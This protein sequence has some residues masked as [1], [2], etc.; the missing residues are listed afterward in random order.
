MGGPSAAIVCEELIALGARRLVRI[1][2]CGALRDGPRAR[3][4]AGGA[5]R[6]CRP[7][8]RAPRSAPTGRVAADP[9]L[10]ERL[11]DGRRRAR[12]GGHHRPLL[13]RPRRERR[14]TGCAGAPPPWRW[15]RPRCCRLAE[16]R[17][18]EAAAVLGVTR[19]AGAG[20]VAAGGAG[21]ARGDRPARGARRL[22][23]LRV[24]LTVRRSCARGTGG[25]PGST[26]ARRAATSRAISSSRPSIAARR[27]SAP[28]LARR[29]PRGGPSRPRCPRGAARAS[30]AGA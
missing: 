24:S 14:R 12:D 20:R 23:A 15:R 1:G 16:L 22:R 29:A 7:T 6:R 25:W 3:R 18:V 26:T 28:S 2:T 8:A 17:G 10:T 5:P 19:R 27:A 21:G 11:V 13:R 9:A 4:P 30:A